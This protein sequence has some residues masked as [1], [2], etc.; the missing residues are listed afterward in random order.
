MAY[1]VNKTDGSTLLNIQEGEVDTTFGLALLG[2]NYLGYGELI[3]E[4]FVKLLENFSSQ[5]APANPL[6]GQ[7]WFSQPGAPGP[8]AAK[9]LK[10]YV[11]NGVWKPLG[12]MYVSITEPSITNLFE[13][14]QWF[15]ITNNVLKIWNGYK[16]VYVSITVGPEPEKT[17]MVLARIIDTSG[18]AHRCVKILVNGVLVAVFSADASYTPAPMNQQVAPPGVSWASEVD[19][20]DYRP[21][22]GANADGTD[23]N[24]GEGDYN[25]QG[26]IGKGLNMNA[27]S[28]FKIRGVAV[29]AEY[30]DVAEIYIGDL[31]YETGT[32]VGLGGDAEVTSTKIDADPT[33]FGV[34]SSRPAYLLNSKAKG[35]KNALPVAVAG[36][37]PV[38]VKGVVKRGDRLVASDEPGVARAAT[39]EDPIWSVVGRALQDYNGEG[40]SKIEATVGAR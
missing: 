3:A 27:S 39:T 5:D 37:I 4:N 12:N 7:L 8:H 15:D 32:L 20:Y 31:S 22:C 34:V 25:D 9:V 19:L 16:W 33:I 36:R 18:V 11:G 13:G 17:G 28:D 21:F 38:K 14:D 26:K 29:E 2:K 10:V 30:A 23:A 6:Q 1:E 40:V 35:R 24:F